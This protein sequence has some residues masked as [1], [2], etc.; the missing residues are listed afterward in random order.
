MVICQF[1]RERHK[2][3][4][5]SGGT[6]CCFLSPFSLWGHE[7]RK[8]WTMDTMLVASLLFYKQ[9]SF[10]IFG[11][12]F[13]ANILSSCFLSI[14]GEK[15]PNHKIHDFIYKLGFTEY[16]TPTWGWWPSGK[17]NIYYGECTGRDAEQLTCTPVALVYNATHS[18]GQRTDGFKPLQRELKQSKTWRFEFRSLVP[19]PTTLTVM[20]STSQLQ[21]DVLRKSSSFFFMI[22][23]MI[24]TKIRILVR[25]PIMICSF[26][27]AQV[28]RF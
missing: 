24:T 19:F 1:S 12:L 3:A 27:M 13:T 20:L 25:G 8:K 26:H 2:T 22:V 15:R 11:S 18:W 10:S 5:L 16:L 9:E 14:K 17:L 23:S 21:A 28:F 4:C 6:I 7:S